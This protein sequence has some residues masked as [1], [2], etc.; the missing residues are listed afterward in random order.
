MYNFLIRKKA[1]LG[2]LASI[3]SKIPDK[4]RLGD[5]PQYLINRP[6][7]L[8]NLFIFTSTDASIEMIKKSKT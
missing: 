5:F 3:I 1:N 4:K 7:N 8:S 6:K 2:E